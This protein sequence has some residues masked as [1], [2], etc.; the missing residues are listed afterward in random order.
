MHCM[1]EKEQG[2]TKFIRNISSSNNKFALDDVSN[3][4]KSQV[5]S[6]DRYSPSVSTH[7]QHTY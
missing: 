6:T 4:E 1:G 7:K 3:F 2:P 5:E